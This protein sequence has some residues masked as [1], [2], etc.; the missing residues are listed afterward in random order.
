VQRADST[1][2]LI[3]RHVFNPSRPFD[4]SSRGFPRRIAV[5]FYKKR[6]N[7]NRET[8]TRRGFPSGTSTAHNISSIVFFYTSVSSF[9]LRKRLIFIPPPHQ[10]R[11][12]FASTSVR[13]I[14]RFAHNTRVR[15]ASALLSDRRRGR[16]DHICPR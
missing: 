7:R 10:R 6:R 15:I 5:F 13:S 16:S 1:F 2:E 3:R 4:F 11:R 9:R 14:S 12:V 8:R